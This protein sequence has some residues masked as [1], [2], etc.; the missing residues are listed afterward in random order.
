M[1]KTIDASTIHQYYKESSTALPPV[2]TKSSNKGAATGAFSGRQG[3]S[4]NH[5]F[6][7]DLISG[8]AAK[9]DALK[10]EKIPSI[11]SRRVSQMPTLGVRREQ[12]ESIHSSKLKDA[13]YVNEG[14]SQAF[15]DTGRKLIREFAEFPKTTK[16]KVSMSIISKLKK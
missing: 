3:R 1:S 4:V 6:N 11:S 14:R 12:F 8:Q 10:R 7:L 13:A 5:Q 2:P 16:N 15:G 9:Y